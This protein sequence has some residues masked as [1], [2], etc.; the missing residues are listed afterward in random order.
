M[1]V[2]QVMKQ[3]ELMACISCLGL[4]VATHEVRARHGTR[5]ISGI[6]TL[7]MHVGDVHGFLAR[8]ST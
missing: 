6:S 2:G 4:R 3:Q 8:T 1:H 7:S 5:S